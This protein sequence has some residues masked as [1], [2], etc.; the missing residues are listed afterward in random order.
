MRSSFGDCSSRCESSSRGPLTAGEMAGVVLMPLEGEEEGEEEN[1][2][3]AAAAAVFSDAMSAAAGVSAGAGLVRF[4]RALPRLPTMIFFAAVEIPPAPDP[5]A[6]F[7]KAACSTMVG[8]LLP[9]FRRVRRARRGAVRGAGDV[10]VV[11]MEVVVEEEEEA[12]VTST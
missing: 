10:E 8:V 5:A 6:L 3:A 11:V 7:G 9:F 1:A 2:A 4:T 12:A